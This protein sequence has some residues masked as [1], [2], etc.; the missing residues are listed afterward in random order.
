MERIIE[1]QLLRCLLLFVLSSN[2]PNLKQLVQKLAR[3]AG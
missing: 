2:W 3:G 1:S